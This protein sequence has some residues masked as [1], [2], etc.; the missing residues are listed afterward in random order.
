MAAAPAG[1]VAAQQRRGHVRGRRRGRGGACG[2][3]FFAR[4]A[5]RHPHDNFAL[6]LPC[7]LPV[8][9]AGCGRCRR[10]LL[11][12]APAAEADRR[13]G[14]ARGL[15]ATG[16]EVDS[17]RSRQVLG[18]TPGLRRVRARAREH[19]LL[20]RVHRALLRAGAPRDSDGV[21]RQK[22]RQWPPLPI[23]E[24]C[25]A[26]HAGL[27]QAAFQPPLAE[28]AVLETATVQAVVGLLDADAV[29]LV[30]QPLA[31]V[32]VGRHC[33]LAGGTVG[34]IAEHH[35]EAMSLVVSPLP[36]VG[37]AIPK[38]QRPKAVFRILRPLPGVAEVHGLV[39]GVGVH[40]VAVPMLATG[41]RVAG[42]RGHCDEGA[43]VDIAV[44]KMKSLL[45]LRRRRRRGRVGAREEVWNCPERHYGV[46]VHLAQAV[47]V[48]AW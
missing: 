12:P 48:E 8:I 25:A 13:K 42:L 27:A 32:A 26:R 47:V 4:R 44:G 31:L 3:A 39:V 1:V 18:G 19:G 22:L 6:L 41:V 30:I 14:R 10:L 15:G 16:A 28:R 24:D 9:A 35:A 38:Q 29:G 34:A 36:N 20:H 17:L 37:A 23:A 33:R 43:L 40:T 11:S 45:D 46:L 2:A 7:G 5:Y 21:L